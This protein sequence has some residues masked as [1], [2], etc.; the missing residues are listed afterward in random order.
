MGIA[1]DCSYV[2]RVEMRAMGT[3]YSLYFMCIMG[4]E[5]VRHYEALVLFMVKICNGS[6]L[7]RVD[8]VI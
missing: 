4:A 1:V 6:M 8:H 7:K 2:W 5:C 3:V